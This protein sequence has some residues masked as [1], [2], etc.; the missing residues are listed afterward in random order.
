M[1]QV[2]NRDEEVICFLKVS[3]ERMTEKNRFHPEALC[4]FF[5]LTTVTISLSRLRKYVSLVFTNFN[6]CLSVKVNDM[7]Q[8]IVI[9][10]FKN[11]DTAVFNSC[12]MVTPFLSPQPHYLSV[13]CFH[14]SQHCHSPPVH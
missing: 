14:N 11:P 6:F 8:S 12:V 7:D 2:V 1:T 13:P 10:Q 3:L 4:I 5:V 9:A